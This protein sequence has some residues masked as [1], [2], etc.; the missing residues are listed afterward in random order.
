MG[1]QGGAGMW[2]LVVNPV[3]WRSKR[4]P[5]LQVT[6][7]LLWA[8]W[9]TVFAD[10]FTLEALSLI[11]AGGEDRPRLGRVDGRPAHRRVADQGLRRPCSP[12]KRMWSVTPR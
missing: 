8:H 9:A 5:L 3:G 1:P 10:V 4:L 11:A 12:W 7:G 2:I 6:A